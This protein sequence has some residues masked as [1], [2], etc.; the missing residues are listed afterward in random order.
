MINHILTNQ[1]NPTEVLACAGIL[2][3]D[4]ALFGQ[5]ITRCRF[6]SCPLELRPDKELC[7]MVFEFEHPDFTSFVQNCTELVAQGDGPRV[8]VSRNGNG[9]AFSLDWFQFAFIGDSGNFAQADKTAFVQRHLDVFKKHAVVDRNMFAQFVTS[10]EPNF[11]SGMNLKKT[12]VDAGEVYEPENRVYPRELFLI[13]ALQLCQHMIEQAVRS[14]RLEY[15]VPTQ[16][17]TFGSAVAALCCRRDD[18]RQYVS[19]VKTFGKGKV[20][21]VGQELLP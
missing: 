13:V 18:S 20:L 2:A 16:W 15:A 8:N 7:G 1:K 10:K 19:R 11:L 14:W 4:A 5:Q 6:I 17:V 3:L 21:A 9:D 12:F